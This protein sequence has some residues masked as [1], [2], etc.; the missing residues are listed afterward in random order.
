MWNHHEDF[1][2]WV[3]RKYLK[4]ILPDYS[5]SNRVL[6]AMFFEQIAKKVEWTEWSKWNDGK[7]IREKNFKGNKLNISVLFTQF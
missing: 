4:Q 1:C 6:S 5:T 2:Y 3:S 7:S